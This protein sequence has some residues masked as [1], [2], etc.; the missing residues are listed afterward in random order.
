MSPTKRTLILIAG[1][2]LLILVLLGV[3]RSFESKS[4]QDEQQHLA[5]PAPSG[6]PNFLSA[7]PGAPPPQP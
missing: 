1:A 5:K 4:Q 3:W 6:L 2:V 7:T